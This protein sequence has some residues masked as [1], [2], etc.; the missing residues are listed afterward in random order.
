ML[1]L[2]NPVLKGSDKQLKL[3]LSLAQIKSARSAESFENRP[4]LP[5]HSSN[6]EASISAGAVKRILDKQRRL[7]G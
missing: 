3:A 2:R 7:H 5:S 4:V 6:R 1:V